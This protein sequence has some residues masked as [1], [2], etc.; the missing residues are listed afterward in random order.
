MENFDEWMVDMQR[1]MDQDGIVYK[2]RFSSVGASTG[3]TL[4]VRRILCVTQH[5]L[6]LP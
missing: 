3:Q 2:G 5:C 4:A 1:L 6:R